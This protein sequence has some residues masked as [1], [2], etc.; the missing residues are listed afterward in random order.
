MKLQKRV[1][2][3]G[4]LNLTYSKVDYSV[5]WMVILRY[6]AK[7]GQIVGEKRSLRVQDGNIVNMYAIWIFLYLN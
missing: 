3:D 1:N 7:K 4:P 2:G 5:P 6:N